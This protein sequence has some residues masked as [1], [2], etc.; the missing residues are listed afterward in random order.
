MKVEEWMKKSPVVDKNGYRYVIHPITDGIPY[1]EPEMLEEVVEWIEKEMPECE[2]IVTMEAMGIPIATALSLKTGIPFNIIRK[3]KYGLEGEIEVLQKTGYSEKKLYINGI[4]KG[5]KIIIVDDVVSTGGTLKAVVN[6]LKKIADIR[7][8]F[9]AVGKGER[10]KLEEEIGMK[11]R[12][13]VDIV[14]DDEIKIL[15][16][17]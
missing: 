10:E 1:I 13:Y 6:A 4:E 12:T 17:E 11:I 8:I 14:V 15:R 2:L 5:S 16:S 7:G 9:I 3:R